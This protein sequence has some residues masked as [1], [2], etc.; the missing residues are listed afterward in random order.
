MD[1][2]A[3][4]QGWVIGLVAVCTEKMV[5][6]MGIGEVAKE[7]MDDDRR[8]AMGRSGVI[9]VQRGEGEAEMTKETEKEWM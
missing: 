2:K 3:R 7:C 5:R 4:C 6:S 9:S 1:A 8:R